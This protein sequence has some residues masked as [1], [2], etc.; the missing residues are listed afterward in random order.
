MRDPRPPGWYGWGLRS[1]PGSPGREI[2]PLLQH[3]SHRKRETNVSIEAKKG[4]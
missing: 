1:A 2:S 4:G 3:P